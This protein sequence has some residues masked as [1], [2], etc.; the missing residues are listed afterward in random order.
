MQ[1]YLLYTSLTWLRKAIQAQFIINLVILQ[2]LIY[3]Q[4]SLSV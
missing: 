1:D 4:S 2:C 3:K